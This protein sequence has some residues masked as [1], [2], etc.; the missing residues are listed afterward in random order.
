[1]VT[2]ISHHLALNENRSAATCRPSGPHASSARTIGFGGSFCGGGAG[3]PAGKA[4]LGDDGEWMEP[5]VYSPMV[6]GSLDK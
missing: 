4:A 1:M 3:R 2:S 5:M 6:E